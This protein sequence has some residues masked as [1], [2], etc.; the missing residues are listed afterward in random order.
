MLERDKNA[1]KEYTLKNIE[2]RICQTVEKHFSDSELLALHSVFGVVLQ[3]ALDILEKYP[4][5]VA[6]TTS[7]KH[8][9]LIEIQG[10]NDR[11][12]RVFPRINFC[13]CQAF[14]RQVIERRIQ[15]TCKHVL[16]ARIATI[17]AKTVPHE[18]TAEQYLML[19]RSVFHI[20]EK[21]NG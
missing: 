8:R 1:S 5:L 16:A 20:E 2:D 6:Y 18:V 12:Y 15:V 10:D 19:L 7:D 14:K 4:T 21:Q 13:P 9:V 11:C 3:R 17:L